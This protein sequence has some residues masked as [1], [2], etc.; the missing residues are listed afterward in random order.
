MVVNKVDAALAADV[1]A[2]IAELQAINPAAPIVRATSPIRL[3]DASTVRGR[4][5][6][7]VEDGPTITHGGMAYGAGYVA[8]LAA[9]AA[10]IVDPRPAAAPEFAEVYQRRP[11]VGEV[12][13]ALGYSTA[14][15]QAL[16][17]TINAADADI[18]VSATPI[19]LVHLLRINKPIVRARYE[20][21]ET[22]EPRLS[23]IVD[24]FVARK[25]IS[26]ERL[27]VNV[28]GN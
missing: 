18:V 16:E 23:A 11:H 20:F 3:D 26:S 15:S 2:A 10:E 21:A 24:A 7:F 25:A 17:L 28:D 22:G 1:G 12:L 4:R 8:A 19:D 13:P 14:Q 6:L 5:V 27:S 9:G